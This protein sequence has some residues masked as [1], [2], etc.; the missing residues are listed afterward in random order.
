MRSSIL[1]MVRRVIAEHDSNNP[2]LIAN[3]LDLNIL[4]HTLPKS[5]DAYI[6]ENVIVFNELIDETNMRWILAHELGH[7]FLHNNLNVGEYYQN[8]LMV[9]GKKE[10]EANIF[11]AELFLYDMDE[12]SLEELSLDQIA[13]TYK[14]PT[15]L[16]QYRTLNITKISNHL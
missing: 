4:Y 7:Y 3:N 6:L 12:I 2:F 11:A 9:I 8:G 15:E 16:I 5:L 1:N 13:C 14:V 10:R